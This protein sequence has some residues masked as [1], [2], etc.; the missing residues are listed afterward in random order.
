MNRLVRIAVFSPIVLAILVPVYGRA[1]PHY[2]FVLPDGYIGWIQVIFNDPHTS[3]LPIQ[4]D[5]ARVIE[6]SESGIT[7]TSDI[8]VL[9]YK[10]HDEF[11]YR[12]PGASRE[13]ELR[14][15]P[16]D[17]IL[18]SVAHGG[19]DI[20][21]TGGKGPGYSWF[22]FIGPPVIRAQIPWADITKVLGYGRKLM[23]PD[24]YP[25]PRRLAGGRHYAN[26]YRP[27]SP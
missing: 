4:K 26:D 2:K 7:R 10:G 12:V 1:K 22:I 9:D 16:S 25:T 8:R 3:A 15:M 11:F 18:A 5:G 13:T 20:M 19:L 17:Y 27:P 6:V 24:V 14:S 23:A 21:D